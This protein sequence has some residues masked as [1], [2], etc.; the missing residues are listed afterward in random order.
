MF[1]KRKLVSTDWPS[2]VPAW[3]SAA[4]NC[5]RAPLFR[6]SEF[7]LSPT[8]NCAPS[9]SARQN[10]SSCARSLRTGI[11][12]WCHCFGWCDLPGTPELRGGASRIDTAIASLGIARVRFRWA[13]VSNLGSLAFAARDL[14]CE[15]LQSL[16]PKMTKVVEPGV[17]FP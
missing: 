13:R 12:I 6:N 17:D 11:S 14:G 9:A 1:E 4:R 3:P 7:S 15:R 5:G 16:D 2:F 10:R 8:E